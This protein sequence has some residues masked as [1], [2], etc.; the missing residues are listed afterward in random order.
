MT[1]NALALLADA[2]APHVS[3]AQVKSMWDYLVKGGVLMVPIGL[4]SLVALAVIIER[5]V[6]LRRSRVLPPA[7]AAGVRAALTQNRR[8]AG[9]ALALCKQDGSPLAKLL[10]A[11]LPYVDSAAGLLEKHVQEAGDRVYRVLRNYLST[12]SVIVA[13][14]PL[15]GLLG[16]VFGMIKAFQTV[17]AAG[18][19]L[20]KTELL[21]R[22]IYEALITTAAGLIV[23]IP[24]LLAHH[25]LV[26]R[27]NRLFHDLDETTTGMFEEFSRPSTPARHAS[28]VHL[29]TSAAPTDGP[30]VAAG[31]A[32]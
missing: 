24:A 27:A 10:A 21:A 11:G 23:A 31:A 5:L 17:A 19:A 18:E 29:P 26:A 22:G 20:G 9:A 14:A 25:A 28:A 8:D 6:S 12:L 2:A 30:L 13:V 1:A 15:L 16:T 7:L 3:Q 4:C 32:V